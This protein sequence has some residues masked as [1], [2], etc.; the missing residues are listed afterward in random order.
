MEEP[1]LSQGK[2]NAKIRQA[3]IVFL[4]ESGISERPPIRRTWAPRGQTPIVQHPFNWKKLSICS[5][6]AYRWDGRRCRLYF[7]IIAGSYNDEKLISFLGQMETQLRG[8]KVIL[9]WDGLPSHRSRQ[10]NQYLNQQQRWLSVVRLPAYAPEMNP[11]ESLWANIL[12]QE[13][14][15]RSVKDLGE[16]VEGVRSGFRRVHSEEWLLH[17]FLNHAGLTIG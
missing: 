15:N 12:G 5:A 8:R 4:D 3:W 17:S 1:D 2:K 11:V 6:I 7:R 10:M 16:M 14:A 9:V 13:L